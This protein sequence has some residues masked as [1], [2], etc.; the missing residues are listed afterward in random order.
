MISGLM[1]L[2]NVKN[3][4]FAIVVC[5]PDRRICSAVSVLILLLTVSL[6]S[7][8]SGIN[9]AGIIVAGSTSVQPYA[10]ILAE[11]YMILHPEAVI[12]IQ[13]GGSSA[14]IM[15]AQTGTSDLGMS[16]RI[17]KDD[18]KSL[19]YVEIARDGLAVIVNPDNPIQNLTLDQISEIYSAGISDWSQVGGTK[20]K[21]HTITR[22]DGSGTRD[23]FVNLVMGDANITPRSIV[24]D[25][26][27]AVRQL[28]ADDPNAIGFISLGLVDDTVKALQLDGVAATRENVIDGSYNLSRPFLFIAQSEP[29]GQTK[30]FL[31]FVLSPEGQQILM[32]EGLISPLE[33]AGT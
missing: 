24:Q 5:R 6:L 22:E 15:A 26:N 28:V 14:G 20:A 2:F 21:I 27:G 32:N 8:C 29:T 7:A 9:E 4:R 16:S 11:E 31:D 3:M 23:A 17:L 30:L 10:E 13:G 25:S 18:E 33:G 19:W 1:L 12:D